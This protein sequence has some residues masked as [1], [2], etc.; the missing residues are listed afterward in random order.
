MTFDNSI[1][2]NQM[3]DLIVKVAVSVCIITLVY[4]FLI[5]Y[6]CISTKYNP[7]KLQIV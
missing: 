5:E 2:F 6:C 3:F 1:I 4:F 7:L